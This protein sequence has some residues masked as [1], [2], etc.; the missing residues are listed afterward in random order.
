MAEKRSCHLCG[1]FLEDPPAV[2]DE[3]LCERTE[4]LKGREI[5]KKLKASVDTWKDAWF[6][7]R[8]IIG[9]L[10]WEHHNCPHETRPAVDRPPNPWLHEG[11][12]VV[13]EGKLVYKRI[14]TGYQLVGAGTSVEAG[15]AVARLMRLEDAK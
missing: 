7:L 2:H 4:R 14:P 5:I 11:E 10:S 13:Q 3:A 6:Q 9:K 15:E 12:S 1:E 8:D